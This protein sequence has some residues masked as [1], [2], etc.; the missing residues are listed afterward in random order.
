MIDLKDRHVVVTGAGTGIGLETASALGCAGAKVCLVGRRREP[1]DAAAAAIG[2]GAWAVPCDVSS[3]ADV[4]RLAEEVQERWGRVDGLVNNA[5]VA[6]MGALNDT[7]PDVWDEVFGINARG[8][9]LMCR[10]LWPLLEQGRSPA[11]VN[12]SSNLAEKAIA[13]MAA[14]NASKAALNQLT[15]SLALEWA[16]TVRVNGVM[17]GVVDT[18]IHTGRGM[19]PEDV[20]RMG[21]IHPLRRIGSPADVASLILFLLSD[22][23]SW[24]TGAIV[25]VD[26]GVL[27]G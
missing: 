3:P 4:D 25:P 20:R 24:I 27:A 22:A 12:V 13:G 11:V 9:Y 21:R 16:P 7:A 10:S 14:Y 5:G 6:P 2:A 1:I 19:S 18:P 15:R 26:G 8:P 23:S 17:P